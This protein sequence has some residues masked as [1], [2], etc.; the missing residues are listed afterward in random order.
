MLRDQYP[1]QIRRKENNNTVL[2]IYEI[3]NISYN[4]KWQNRKKNSQSL[5]TLLLYNV[6]EKILKYWLRGFKD[7]AEFSRNLNSFLTYFM[8]D[9]GVNHLFLFKASRCY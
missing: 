3:Q 4:K 6:A 7:S 2:N 8:L 5:K 1:G 9:H